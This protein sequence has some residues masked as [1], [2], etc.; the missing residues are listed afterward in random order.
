MRVI[1]PLYRHYKPRENWQFSVGPRKSDCNLFHIPY[2]MVAAINDAEVAMLAAA[3]VTAVVAV[4]RA[5]TSVL[6]VAKYPLKVVRSLA[7]V[8]RSL[9]KVATSAARAVSVDAMLVADPARLVAEALKLVADVD[10]ELL[11]ELIV[12]KFVDSVARSLANVVKYV[13]SAVR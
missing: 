13:F 8:V 4:V 10:M 3:A 5:V 9:L 6:I 12:A 2:R 7:S 11:S 1:R